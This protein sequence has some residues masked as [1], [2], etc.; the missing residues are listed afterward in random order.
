MLL[1]C[2]SLLLVIVIVLSSIYIFFSLT[3]SSKGCA[4]SKVLEIPTAVEDI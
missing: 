3:D 1:S 2:G 4:T